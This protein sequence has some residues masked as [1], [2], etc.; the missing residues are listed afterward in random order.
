[1][2]GGTSRQ[3][4]QLAAPESA[5][6]GFVPQSPRPSTRGSIW[7][8]GWIVIAALVSVWTLGGPPL[9]EPDEGRNA[10]VAREM[11]ATG[12]SVLPHL[13]GLPYLDK[14]VVFFAA[15]AASI[16]VLGADEFAARLPSLLF[17]LAT[18]ALVGWFGMT[19][20]GAEAGLVAAL[21]TLTAPLTVAFSHIVIMDSTL[22]FFVVLAIISFH[23]AIERRREPSGGPWLPWTLVAWAAVGIGILTKGPVA[24]AVPLLVVTPY[25]LWR[26][27]AL[28]VWHPLGVLAVA[29][30]VTPWVW[31]VS[32]VIPNFLGYVVVTETVARMTSDELHRSQPFWFFIPV[33]LAGTFPWWLPAA[34]GLRP[35]RAASDSGQG[36]AR[37]L[38]ILWLAAPLLLFSLSRGK[39]TQYVLPLVPAVALLAAAGWTSRRRGMRTAAVCWGVLGLAL[40]AVAG[41][42]IDIDPGRVPHELAM[43][44]AAGL[45]LAALLGSGLAWFSTGKRRLLTVIGLSLPMAIAPVVLG[46]VVAAVA[47]SRSARGLA[48]A[49]ESRAGRAPELLW[50]EAYAAGLSFYLERVV[51]LASVNGDELRSNYIV[52]NPD[53]YLSKSGPLRPPPDASALA[54]CSGP[55]VLLISSGRRDLHEA[56][57]AAGVPV[58]VEEPRWTAFGPQ[59]TVAEGGA[60]PAAAE[61]E[62]AQ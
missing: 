57:A 39:Q 48:E 27:T 6:A 34:D 2:T 25:G 58:L 17:A 7:L 4:Q 15:C 26:R 55:R 3:P 22:S 41:G 21:A 16:E 24:L 52:R 42:L 46:P 19:L 9:V 43:R 53:R 20:F 23:R 40:M 29:A 51:P 59:C 35:S 50:I 31:A 45:G 37:V 36:P 33:M 12:N 1:M 62:P 10:E 38:L 32:Q 56:I 5:S 30:I 28:A 47:E 18:V 60:N 61:S 11:A 44:S 14:P 49:V 8:A 13:N 54:V